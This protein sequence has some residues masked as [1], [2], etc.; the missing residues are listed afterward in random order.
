MDFVSLYILTKK[1]QIK[2]FVD[3]CKLFKNIVR[4]WGNDIELCQQ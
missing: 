1:E 3:I 2:Q 4:K